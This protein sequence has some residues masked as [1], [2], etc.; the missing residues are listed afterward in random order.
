MR[1]TN[2]PAICITVIDCGKR[3]IPEQLRLIEAQIQ[4]SGWRANKNTLFL[5]VLNKGDNQ[6]QAN[7]YLQENDLGA[8]PSMGSVFWTQGNP[9]RTD[10]IRRELIK[11]V[12][13]VPAERQEA[14]EDNQSHSANRPRGMPFRIT[15]EGNQIHIIDKGFERIAKLADMND[16]RITA[17]LWKELTKAG[18]TKAIKKTGIKSGDMIVLGGKQLTWE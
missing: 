6:E 8:T 16:G 15:R 17:Q 11:I 4:D 7:A 2:T 12:G 13:E 5:R 14:T 9:S 18:I 1:S 3:D 10:I